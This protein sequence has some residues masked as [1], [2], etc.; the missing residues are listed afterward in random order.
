[1]CASQTLDR[2]AVSASVQV[3]NIIDDMITKANSKNSLVQYV[4]VRGYAFLAHRGHRSSQTWTVEGPGF[5]IMTLPTVVTS[6]AMVK[7]AIAFE[8]IR[9]GDRWPKVPATSGKWP[10]AAGRG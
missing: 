2:S 3:S 1:M 7:E 9:L 4:Y 5:D 10:M 6:L 8:V